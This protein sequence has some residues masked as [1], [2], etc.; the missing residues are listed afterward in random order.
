MESRR[1]FI[2]RNGGLGSFKIQNYAALPAPLSEASIKARSGDNTF[3]NHEIYQDLQSFRENGSNNVII[4][5]EE[6]KIIIDNNTLL[7]K[8]LDPGGICSKNKIF[9]SKVRFEAV[10]ETPETTI[11]RRTKQITIY[12][13]GKCMRRKEVYLYRAS[14][15]I[16]R[17]GISSASRLGVWI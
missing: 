3:F 5:K 14:A 17:D 9:S 1:A 2:L 12:E 8:E 6:Q 7:I 16:P 10:P 4:S 11:E 13:E 15:K